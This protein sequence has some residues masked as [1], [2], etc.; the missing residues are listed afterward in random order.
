[1]SLTQHWSSLSRI[2]AQYGFANTDGSGRRATLLA[3][4]H[5][6]LVGSSQDDKSTH[7]RQQEVDLQRYIPANGGYR[8]NP[9]I[10]QEETRDTLYS[11]AIL[12]E[13]R[14]AK[15]QLLRQFANHQSKWVVSIPG[16]S[17]LEQGKEGES[18]ISTLAQL[19]TDDG[20]LEIL[21]TCR[22]LAL[23]PEDYDGNGMHALQIILQGIQDGSLEVT[24]F[25]MKRGSQVMEQRAWSWFGQLLQETLE[26]LLATN[27]KEEET[28]IWLESSNKI[29]ST[30]NYERALTYVRSG[31]IDTIRLLLEYQAKK[32]VA[33]DM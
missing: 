20:W 29:S 23:Q 31:E 11:S 3:P 16:A 10:D 14:D 17:D 9:S 19:D 7:R 25:Q 1:M 4:F 13:F 18:M 24:A 15:L 32:E 21:S 2:F 22:L 33:A 12:E 26:L 27:P 28:S 8:N 30:V 6:V 5:R